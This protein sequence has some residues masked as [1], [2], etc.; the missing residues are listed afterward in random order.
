M[1]LFTF[2]NAS[3][4]DRASGLVAIKPSGVPYERMRPED[5]PIVDL[6]GK[7]VD[8]A[9]RPSSDLDTHLALYRFSAAIGGVVHTHS[10]SATAWA[11]ARKPIPCFGTTHADYFRGEIPVTRELTDEEVRREEASTGDT[12]AQR[13][14]DAI[15]WKCRR[16]WWPGMRRSRGD[17]TPPRRRITRCCWKKWL[18]WRWRR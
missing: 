9:M 4:I 8:G 3:G 12:I 6:D 1:A 10:R 13:W 16:R 15:L 14:R 5:L 11:Q 18:R 2:G 17:G 7:V